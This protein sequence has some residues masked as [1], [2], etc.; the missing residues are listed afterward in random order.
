MGRKLDSGHSLA[1]RKNSKSFH[2]NNSKEEGAEEE[3]PESQNQLAPEVMTAMG[4]EGMKIEDYNASEKSRCR[5]FINVI[6]AFDKKWSNKLSK[7][8]RLSIELPLIFFAHIFNRGFAL[9]PVMLFV[10]IGAFRYDTWMSVNGYT[11]PPTVDVTNIDR[12]LLG[13]CF[14]SF[15]GLMITLMVISNTIL[16]KTIKRQRPPLPE[17]IYT[18]RIND[19]RSRE[20]GTYAMPSGDSAV[21]AIF[22]YILTH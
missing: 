10:V 17:S 3:D 14:A 12:F 1:A 20:T 4:T 2:S 21:G 6:D 22:C 15:F 19:L 7:E 18:K 13:V 9:I 5:H 8:N 11:T 16:K